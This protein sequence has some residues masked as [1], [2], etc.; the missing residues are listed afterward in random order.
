MGILRT[1]TENTNQGN[2]PRVDISFL[3]FPVFFS[4]DMTFECCVCRKEVTYLSENRHITSCTRLCSRVFCCNHGNVRDRFYQVT[5][6]AKSKLGAKDMKMKIARRKERPV[7]Y[8]H[9]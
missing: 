3:E 1:T 5:C 9:T 6:K 8:R 2:R 7:R 4:F